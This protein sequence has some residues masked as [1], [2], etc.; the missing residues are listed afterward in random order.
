M[1]W[2]KQ[3][4]DKSKEKQLHDGKIPQEKEYEC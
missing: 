3:A 4:F 2:D 1:V